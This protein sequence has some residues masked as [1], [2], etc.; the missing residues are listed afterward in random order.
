MKPAFRVS[1]ADW[2]RK[3][4]YTYENPIDFLHNF[5]SLLYSPGAVVTINQTDEA[6]G[7]SAEG[8]IDDR[9]FEGAR[10]K[11][12][13]VLAKIVPP[14]VAY[15]ALTLGSGN[16]VLTIRG[17]SRDLEVI[18]AAERLEGRTELT[19]TRKGSLPQEAARLEWLFR[20]SD[21]DVIL[22]GSRLT[23]SK[24]GFDFQ[25]GEVRGR[26]KYNP[27]R[28]GELLFYD[29]GRYVSSLPFIPGVEIFL[30]A[31]GLPTTVTKSKV[32]TRGA[33]KEAFER[34]QG[35]LP[36]LMAQ[37]LRSPYAQSLSEESYQTLIRVI[38]DRFKDNKEISD[39]VRENIRLADLSGNINPSWSIS[40]LTENPG[41]EVSP[42][43]LKL[44]K[45]LTGE[46][47]HAKRSVGEKMRP[48]W[49]V[50]G[51]A[52]AS[53]AT[54]LAVAVFGAQRIHSTST[55]RY[56]AGEHADL[57]TAAPSFGELLLPG[58]SFGGEELGGDYISND[59]L[60]RLLMA[61]GGGGGGKAPAPAPFYNRFDTG[62]HLFMRTGKLIWNDSVPLDVLV[63]DFSVEVPKEL[64]GL[65]SATTDK[66]IRAVWKYIN[67]NFEYGAIPPYKNVLYPDFVAALEAEQK[68]I[69]S[70]ANSYAAALLNQLGVRN[71]RYAVGDH[72]GTPHAWLELK[73]G[74]KW[75]IKD[76]TPTKMAADLKEQM[77]AYGGGMNDAGVLG[78]MKSLADPSQILGF[79][80]ETLLRLSIDPAAPFEETWRLLAALSAVSL[81][82]AGSYEA[83]TLLARHR[84]R[85]KGAQA[86]VDMVTTPDEERLKLIQVEAI[87]G[88]VRIGA[89]GDGNNGGEPHYNGGVLFLPGSMLTGSPLRVA[90]EAA[91]ALPEKERLK[92]YENI[93]RIA[94]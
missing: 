29:R 13:G 73:K 40:F 72:Y 34:L 2:F 91:Q 25:Q 78:E 47:Y 61:K 33:G 81:I 62:N 5:I 74:D 68:L 56:A 46:P 35:F 48:N 39:V 15:E 30:Y 51:V 52:L 7:L 84:R 21:L 59:R 69:C 80:K 53:L 22:N 20:G 19:V 49:L 76:F 89:I 87:L 41:M 32:I 85:A 70:S 31:H 45:Q 93:A 27:S 26:A 18:T 60:A 82:G 65:A 28:E 4:N 88:G 55:D 66:K 23:S 67:A 37:A 9:F 42:L 77:S 50:K 11:D 44:Y 75:V 79:Y 64:A 16:K 36:S 71:I 1:F 94:R 58:Q 10:G 92:A 3:L 57:T 90:A 17:E 43:E 38:F 86:P 54:L 8:T 6:I 83:A 24:D 14:V 63:S 12:V